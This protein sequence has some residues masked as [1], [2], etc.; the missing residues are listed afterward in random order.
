MICQIF[1]EGKR[2]DLTADIES[3]LTFAIDD[4]KDFSKRSTTWSKTI[5]LPGTSSN[6]AV[7]GNLFDTGISNEYDPLL[8]NIGYN[9]NASK[10][11]RCII[12][13]DFMQTFKGTLRMLEIV[14][15][16]NNIEYEVALNGELTGLNVALTGG[17]LEDLDFSAYDH[18]FLVS[19]ITA[20]WMNPGGSGY[21]YPLID[22]GDASVDKHDWD[23]KT[24]R[25]ALYVKE[26]LDK[27]FEAAGY[28]YDCPLFETNRFKKLIVPQNR[29]SLT[30]VTEFL[31]NAFSSFGFMT[32][33]TVL[34][35]GTGLAGKFEFQTLSSTVFTP[36]GPPITRFT[37][38]PAGPTNVLLLWNL[39]I[40]YFS[41]WPTTFSIKKNGVVIYSQVLPS[42]AM[43]NTFITIQEA[44]GQADTISAGDYYELWMDGVFAHNY[45]I[46]FNG[47]QFTVKA[48]A[49]TSVPISIGAQLTI[50][51][52]L[53]KNI[54]QVDFLLS[55]VKL[56]NL[57]VYEDRFEERLIH[58][59]PFIDFYD[60]EVVDD[61]TYKMNRDQVIKI[62]PLSEVN[63]KIYK[64]NYKDDGDYYNDLYKKRYNL[65][66]GSH[67]YDSRFEFASQTNSLEL[68]FSSTPL[69]GYSGEDKVY[70]T[71][72]KKS[73]DVEES[74]DSN[75]RIMQT[76]RKTGV[77]SWDIKDGVTVVTSRTD[78]GYA[79]H[80]DDPD[81]PVN[82]LNFGIV[83]ELFFLISSGDLT[84]TQFNMYWSGYMDEITHKDS[85]MM[86]ARFYLTARDI[87]ELNFKKFKWVDGVLYRLNKI[88]DYNVSQPNDCLVELLNVINQNYRFPPGSGPTEDYALLWSNND[89]IYWDGTDVILYK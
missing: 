3:L 58:I 76:V 78:Y 64:F 38:I 22:Y 47:G 40:Q 85:K 33:Q 89:P 41:D 4:I 13:Q 61:W 30:T 84:K 48:I 60:E 25:P 46:K 87:F 71:I 53:P 21:Y 14:K 52:S 50:N 63:S 86:I 12:F 17:L 82:D 54:R 19:N 81:D 51:D 26:Y 37:Y 6:N 68:I 42:T 44:I 36:D 72:F 39:S 43:I 66:Y 5:V 45:T 18:Q 49:P 56:W 57:Y 24:F 27:M 2:L 23:V 15:D 62:K 34:Y 32:P 55:I 73:G 11:A 70:P 9:F 1:V 65:T 28:T 35:S 29:K 69:V 75:I 77:A 59:S 10:A 88:I 79:G 31:A 20:S 83:E 8:D 74:I 67:V 80:F 7:F 16:K